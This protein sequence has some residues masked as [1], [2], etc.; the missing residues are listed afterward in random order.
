MAQPRR[1][2]HAVLL[3]IVTPGL[4]HLYCGRLRHAALAF[5]SAYS[6]LFALAVVELTGPSGIALG[7][8]FLVALAGAVA[9][10]VHA[11]ITAKHTPVPFQ[12]RKFN[13]WWV[14]VAVILFTIFVW[15]PAVLALIRSNLVEAYR[16]PSSTME[17]SILV[18][19]YVFADRR[20]SAR[21]I[22]ARNDVIIFSSQTHPGV[23]IIKRVAGL[24]GDTLA[25]VSGHLVRNGASVTEPWTAPFHPGDSVP[26]TDNLPWQIQHLLRDPTGYRPTAQD[27]GPLRVPADS[28]F[29]LGDN[30]PN[31]YDSR[32]WGAL[33]IARILGRPT[34]VYF[35]IDPESGFAVRWNRIGTRPWVVQP[36]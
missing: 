2:W 15:H 26:I 23:A 22:P 3:A 21:R 7:V 9:L 20:G 12:P 5:A 4:G 34:S 18:G 31:S 19:D 30:R 32:Y 17:P 35:S 14:Y 24:P 13:R 6:L 16:I 33:A 11:G 28:L 1:A 10:I 29:V 25:M 8:A 27:W 36:N